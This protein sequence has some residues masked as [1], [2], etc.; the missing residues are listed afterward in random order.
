MSLETGWNFLK[1]EDR[2]ACLHKVMQEDPFCLVLAFPCGPW[3]PLTRLRPSVILEERRKEGRVLLNF[4]LVLARLQLKRNAHLILENPKCSMAWTLPEV[5]QFLES[6]AV[7]CVDFDQCAFQLKNASG[8][9]HRKPTRN[10]V[11]TTSTSQFSEE[12]RSQAELV[13]TRL[14]LLE[15]LFEALRNSST[16]TMPS[17]VKCWLLMGRRRKSLRRKEVQPWIR[18]TQSQRSLQLMRMVHPK[19]ESE[20]SS[21]D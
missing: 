5:I 20:I 17:V 19:P 13:I 6:A 21:I 14:H 1:K 7:E 3:S 10:A 12:P 15:L 9:L 16:S 4:A 18:T 2:N 8:F 11:G